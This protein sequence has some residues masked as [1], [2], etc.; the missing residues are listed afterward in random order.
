MTIASG[1]AAGR[2]VFLSQPVQ[3]EE[4]AL[5]QDHA[6][7]GGLGERDA[8]PSPAWLPGPRLATSTAAS[9]AIASA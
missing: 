4:D 6:Y 5:T 8:G 9:A 7:D 1:E 2:G 3:R